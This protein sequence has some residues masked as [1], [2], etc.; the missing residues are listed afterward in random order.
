M[1]ASVEPVLVNSAVGEHAV[2][3]ATLALPLAGA[4]RPTVLAAPLV[5]AAWAR[6]VA[7]EARRAGT[8]VRTEPV[9]TADYAGLTAEAAPGDHDALH[10]LTDWFAA[11]AEHAPEEGEF[12]TVRR[13]FLSRTPTSARWSDAVRRA[14]FGDRH[15][16]GVGHGERVAHATS[17]GPD[18]VRA[19]AR[20]LL[21]A[22]ADGPAPP[23]RRT[24]PVR[25]RLPA[26]GGA[27]CLLGTPGVALGSDD[28]YA[29]HVAW[30]MLG[31]R[32]GLLDRRLR[33]E[34]ALTYSL[35][36]FSREFAEGGYGACFAACA[37][38][39]EDEVAE[40]TGEVL[41][42]LE[43]G[44]FDTALVESAKERLVIGNHRSLQSGR[45]VTE[46]LC[47]YRIAGTDPAGITRYARQVGGVTPGQVA[48]VARS[49]IGGDHPG[50]DS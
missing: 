32:D 31:G 34:H 33:G 16:Y 6:G 22:R 4:S 7:A 46:R 9:V 23:V 1:T 24:A 27:C 42:A 41:R 14:L 49:H 25:V 43:R 26:E 47:G 19:A 3:A 39:T 15:R 38:G 20:E 21:G 8:P 12:A 36:A 30:A 18:D 28:K 35:A 40:R 2:A 17:H 37:P 48:D 5:A 45:G 29:L 11:V 13:S 44:A 50:G 10:R